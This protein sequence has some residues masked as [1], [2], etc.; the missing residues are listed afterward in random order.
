MEIP[1]GLT[2]R[3]R[4]NALSKAGDIFTEAHRDADALNGHAPD[5]GRSGEQQLDTTWAQ[6]SHFRMW[7]LWEPRE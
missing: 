6:N 1:H 4:N 5:D 7:N 3:R 2:A